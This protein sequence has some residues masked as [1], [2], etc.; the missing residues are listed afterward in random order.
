MTRPSGPTSPPLASH[1]LA[2]MTDALRL[3]A[4]DENPRQLLCLELGGLVGSETSLYVA[5]EPCHRS[6]PVFFTDLG[7][8]ATTWS[9]LALGDRI[10]FAHARDRELAWLPIAHRGPRRVGYLFARRQP[11]PADAASVLAFAQEPAAVIEDLVRRREPKATGVPGVPAIPTVDYGLTE[12]EQQVLVL[13]SRGLLARTIATQLSLSPRTV[14]H[15]LGRIYDKLGVRD[16][17]A[18]ALL[19]RDAGLLGQPRGLVSNHPG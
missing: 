17:L 18:A 11:F 5:I 13:L 10:C 8:D 19:A 9:P 6:R 16:R 14:H 3:V 12:R 4:D 15:Y 2:V 7:R 1:V